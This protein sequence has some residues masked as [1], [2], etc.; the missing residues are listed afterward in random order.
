MNEHNPVAMDLAKMPVEAPRH[1][2]PALGEL[3]DEAPDTMALHTREAYR[4][5]V[6]RSLDAGSPRAAIVGG[7][8]VAAALRAIW[9]LS[10]NDNPYADWVLVNIGERLVEI[11]SSLQRETQRGEDQLRALQQRG[12]HFSVLQSRVPQRV[13]LGFRSPYGYAVADL[14]VRF[15]TCNRVLKTLVRKDLLPD[16]DGRTLIYS[17]TRRLRGLFEEPV[18]FERWLMRDELR[19]LSRHD[20]LPAAGA[21]ASK[22]VQAVLALFGP[23]PRD[24]FTG[25]RVPRHSQRRVELTAQE[26]RLLQDADLSGSPAAGDG[27]EATLL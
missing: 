14:V 12:L 18:R 25:T 4:L 27:D 16:R 26:L 5:F 7:R 2:L 19:P 3:V 8:R 11:G 22:R 23:V 13:E 21:E 9:H 17:Y 10:G 6:G 20:F 1:S 24:V 15:D